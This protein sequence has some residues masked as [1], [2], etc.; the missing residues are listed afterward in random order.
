MVPRNE[1]IISG[2]QGQNWKQKRLT[3]QD[4]QKAEQVRNVISS[5]SLVLSNFKATV[6]LPL[7]VYCVLSGWIY[8]DSGNWLLQ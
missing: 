4:I 3:L 2:E 1:W 7:T 5:C 8:W 6:V